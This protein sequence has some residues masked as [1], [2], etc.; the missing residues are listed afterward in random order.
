MLL[1]H[2]GPAEQGVSDMTGHPRRGRGIRPDLLSAARVLHLFHHGHPPEEFIESAMNSYDLLLDVAENPVHAREM[3]LVLDR[4]ETQIRADAKAVLAHL[5]FMKGASACSSLGLP[6]HASRDDI[7]KRRKR[8][9]LLFHPDHHPDQKSY[10][11]ITKRINEAYG[12]I[13]AERKNAWLRDFARPFQPSIRVPAYPAGRHSFLRHLPLLILS[14]AIIIALLSVLLLV[15]KVMSPPAGHNT[16]APVQ[17][18]RPHGLIPP[19]GRTGQD[20]QVLIFPVQVP[21]SPADEVVRASE[22]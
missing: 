3:T 17:T 6:A 14:A 11:E 20:R 2:T 13:L 9:L 21:V 19:P 16:P 4:T 1:N 7:H 8:L 10:E 18:G 12:D 5:L 15:R 22:S